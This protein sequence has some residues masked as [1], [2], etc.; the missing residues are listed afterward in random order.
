MEKAN[1]SKWSRAAKEGL[2]LAAVTVICTFFEALINN[3][4]TNILLWLIQLVASIW[5]LRICMKK[6]GN[7]NPS[8]STF[9]Y[10][11]TVCFLSAV[12]C[13]VWAFVLYGVI[14]TDFVETQFDQVFAT[15][16]A[17]GQAMPEGFED[18]MGYV[19]DNYPKLASIGTFIKCCII[20]LI[21]SGI[22]AGSTSR[23]RSI[24][25]DASEEENQD[26]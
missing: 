21:F 22:L 26:R 23:N 1:E 9:R 24:F 20:G 19:M 4:I 12:I 5:I 3:G 25:E 6:Y 7:D 15:F 11:F 17:S 14:F 13:S 16:E 8:V 18:M 10:G 2:I